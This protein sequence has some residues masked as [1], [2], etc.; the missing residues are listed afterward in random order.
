MIIAVDSAIT[1]VISAITIV[2]QGK[3]IFKILISSGSNTHN[4]I[5]GMIGDKWITWYESAI[6]WGSNTTDAKKPK[7]LL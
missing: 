2:N 6:N 4:C 3:H 5:E 7:N 1:T